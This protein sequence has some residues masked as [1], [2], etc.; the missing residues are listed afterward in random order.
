MKSF[1]MRWNILIKI[2]IFKTLNHENIIKY[3]ESF[4]NKNKLC[5]IME[6]A[7]D[8]DFKSLIRSHSKMSTKIE[9]E[10]IW[11]WFAQ[12]CNALNYIHKKKIIHRDIKPGNVF[13]KGNDVIYF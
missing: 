6:Y 4:I 11:K 7:E 5:V 10:S 1:S 12:L 13:L 8:G 2:N 3:Y 9:E